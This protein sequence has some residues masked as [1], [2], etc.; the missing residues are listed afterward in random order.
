MSLALPLCGLSYHV[1]ALRVQWRPARA[2]LIQSRHID[3]LRNDASNETV[4]SCPGRFWQKTATGNK[5]T[6]AGAVESFLRVAETSQNVH[7]C[8]ATDCM[9]VMHAEYKDISIECGLW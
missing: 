9:V 7:S 8:L 4:K 6:E 5:E 1:T 2:A 3:P